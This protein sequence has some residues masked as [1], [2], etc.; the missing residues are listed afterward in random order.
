MNMILLVDVDTATVNMFSDLFKAH[1]GNIEIITAGSTKEVP[2]IVSRKKIGMVIIDLKMP[3]SED[4]EFL[5]YM[6]RDYPKI[7]I[8]VMTAFGTPDI[9]RRINSLSTCKYYEKPIDIKS[10]SEKIFE[11]L[12]SG[13]G[14]QIRGIA[15]S[16]FLQMSEM[17]KTTCRLKIKTDDDIG[18]MYLLKGSLIAAE[19]G[20][21]QGNEAAYEIIS[22]DDTTIEI[23]KTNVKK[24]KEINMP[25][26]NILMEGL[27]IKDEREVEKKEGEKQKKKPAK[28]K[29]VEKEKEP[30]PEDDGTP[31]K[32]EKDTKPDAPTKDVKIDD[33]T[34]RLK[35]K[36]LIAVFAGIILTMAIAAAG[37]VVWSKVIKPRQIKK[38]FQNVLAD[39]GRQKTLEEKEIVLEEYIESHAPNQYTQDAEKK[40]KE[41]FNL[42]QERDF[43]IVLNRINK[44]PIDGNYKSEATAIYTA[45]LD[46]FP[47]G[48]HAGEIKEGL[49]GIPA[50]LDESDFKNLKKIDTNDYEKRITAYRAYL[51]DH[52]K[53]KHRKEVEKLT[54]DMGEIYYRYLKKE[55][56]VCDQ[57][58]D[59]NRCVALLDEYIA[60]YRTSR[61]IPEAQKNKNRMQAKSVLFELA[62]DAAKTD[63]DYTAQKNIYLNYL[64]A[65]PKTPAKRGITTELTKLNKKIREKEAWEEIV[66]YSKNKKNNVFDR[67]SELEKYVATKIRA[68]YQKGAKVIMKRLQ[69][70]KKEVVRR[71]KLEE[72]QRRIEAERLAAIEQEK[73]RIEKE[74]SNISKQLDKSS[75]RY[76]DNADGTVTDKQTG[77]MWYILDSHTELKECLTFDAAGEYVKKLDVGSHQD[78]R[79]P[80][81]NDLLLILN[82][83][84]T[85]PTSGAKWYW[86]SELYWK[87]YFEF[88]KIIKLKGKNVW[89]KE[90]AGLTQ[91]GAVRA[92]RP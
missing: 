80:T 11:E 59:W 1:S 87:G 36:R 6:N 13:V 17:E 3:D 42:I 86:T 21:L 76:I 37:S 34:R 23:E 2:N 90:E 71:Q 74:K 30:K 8:I 82:N 25:L 66:Q 32:S 45:Y 83:D 40:I 16:S 9:E 58:K 35:N 12:D 67:I 52:P 33:A 31:K 19:T 69:E 5:G 27:K 55:I 26:M 43:E 53:G 46:K 92:V 65:N 84:P 48:I 7:P 78:W 39:V 73:A 22:W 24:K 18:H 70:E 77:L 75:G 4:L 49:A 50:L 44:L 41:I 63:M 28:P 91:C 88:V 54:S 68:Q 61:F 57:Q 81:T 60:V 79:L 51:E 85:F 38:E 15:L 47:E 14:G 89:G 64:K 72:E 20:L 56:K 62:K 29:P 10:I